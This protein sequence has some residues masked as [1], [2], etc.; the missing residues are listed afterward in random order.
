MSSTLAT[1]TVR[2]AVKEVSKYTAFLG[3]EHPNKYATAASEAIVKQVE[4]YISPTADILTMYTGQSRSVL[5]CLRGYT[6]AKSCREHMLEDLPTALRGVLDLQATVRNS[7]ANASE[8]PNPNGLSSD[9][10]LAVLAY[11]SESRSGKVNSL[12]YHVNN[13]LRLRK[14]EA[15]RLL[16]PYLSYLMSAMEKFPIV[17]GTVYRGVAIDGNL[18]EIKEKYSIG[19]TVDWSSFTSTSTNIASAL[20]FREN[21][22]PFIMFQIQVINGRNMSMYSLFPDEEEVLLSP[23]SHFFI[24]ECSFPTVEYFPVVEKDISN[25]ILVKLIETKDDTL[26]F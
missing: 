25:T 10:A 21:G 9:E 17:K 2:K 19:T 23:N 5:E 14:S 20:K 18:N 1:L 8:L 4:Y 16:K 11:T 13:V 7:N 15:L 24:S 3:W 26:L 12:Y 6:P 22:R